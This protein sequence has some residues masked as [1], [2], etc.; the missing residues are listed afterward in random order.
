[1]CARLNF[2]SLMNR[3]R[4]GKETAF[5]FIFSMHSARWCQAPCGHV[6]MCW[7]NVACGRGTCERWSFPLKSE[8]CVTTCQWT[9]FWP[10]GYFVLFLFILYFPSAPFYNC[11]VYIYV[12]LLLFNML[13]NNLK[14]KG[15]FL[16]QLKN[17]SPKS[18]TIAIIWVIFL[19]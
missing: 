18:T 19:F 17:F 12:K 7:Y 11:L 13:N 9:R 8:T 14:R 6:S 3:G 10:D 4:E 5:S 16:F 1:M 15:L 2:Y